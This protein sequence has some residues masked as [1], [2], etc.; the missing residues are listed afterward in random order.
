VTYPFDETMATSKET[1]V[2]LFHLW[3]QQLIVT[4]KNQESVARLDKQQKQVDVVLLLKKPGT[5]KLME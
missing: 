1:D 2:N 4:C 5:V 3:K